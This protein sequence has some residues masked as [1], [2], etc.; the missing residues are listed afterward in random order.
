MVSG[1]VCNMKGERIINPN[2]PFNAKPYVFNVLTI[3]FWRTL[4]KKKK[5]FEKK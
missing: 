5:Q 4:C 1:G 2:G 3:Q